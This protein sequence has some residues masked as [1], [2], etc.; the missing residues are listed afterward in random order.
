MGEGGYLFVSSLV[1]GDL[2]MKSVERRNARAGWRSAIAGYHY[3]PRRFNKEGELMHT[4]Y[5]S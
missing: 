4:R 2:W 3:T 1:W 5:S